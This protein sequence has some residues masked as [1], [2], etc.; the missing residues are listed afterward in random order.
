MQIRTDGIGQT[1]FLTNFGIESRAK[2]AAAQDIVHHQS[3]VPVGVAALKACLAEDDRALR[4]IEIDHIGLT[5]GFRRDVC[6]FGQ[7]DAFR[8]STEP[9]IK[10][11]PSSSAV[12][13][14]VTPTIK[15][16]CAKRCFTKSTKS[17]RLMALI[18]SSVPLDGIE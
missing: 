2:P 5:A 6:N 9:A 1:A 18:V 15:I 13:L 14:P 16:F 7:F 11:G 4:Y 10:E 17:A 3:R 8:Q 12:M